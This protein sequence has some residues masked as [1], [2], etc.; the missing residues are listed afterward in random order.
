M[1]NALYLSALICCAALAAPLSAFASPYRTDC[2]VE[3]H[4]HR[5]VRV[6][7]RVRHR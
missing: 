4:H 3:H 7:H 6:C 1:K 2:H 5:P